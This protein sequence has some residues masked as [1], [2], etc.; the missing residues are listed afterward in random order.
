[1]QTIPYF[2]GSGNILLQ[3]QLMR[4]VGAL[5]GALTVLLSFFFIR[6]ILP[7]VR[8]APTVGALC[9]ALQPQLAFMSGSVNPDT[10]Q[11]TVSAALFLCLARAFHRGF[12]QRLAVVL[13]ILMIVGFATKLTFIGVAAGVLAA[14][15]VLAVHGVRSRGWTGLR[16]PAIAVGIALAP[17]VLYMLH[18]IMSSQPTLGVI[19]GLHHWRDPPKIT[20]P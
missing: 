2:L 10:L 3:L 11:A 13:G 12:S 4:L 14:L 17:V 18:N 9:L 7:S 19:A 6:E 8:W 20:L 15:V 5:L 16:S 1:M